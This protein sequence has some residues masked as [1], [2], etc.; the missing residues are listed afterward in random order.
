MRG[1]GGLRPPNP[2]NFPDC[3]T[4]VMIRALSSDRAL[5]RSETS[6]SSRERLDRIH[7]VA[8]D[9][10]N[11]WTEQSKNDD[12]DNG[13]Q[14]ENERVLYEALAFFF[15]REQ[16]VFSPPFLRMISSYITK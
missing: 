8:E 16:H 14:N 5:K 13:Y 10:T 1:L 11:C 9:P 2:L 12:Y 4:S 7:D 3:V 6:A 15:G